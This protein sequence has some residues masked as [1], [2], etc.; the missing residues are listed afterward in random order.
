MLNSWSKRCACAIHRLVGV[1]N[2]GGV[3]RG[4]T[5]P[6]VSRL[7]CTC[8]L[9]MEEARERRFLLLYGSQT[10]QA[11]AIAEK[12]RDTARERGLDP[13]MHCISQS[14]KKV[15]RREKKMI[16]SDKRQCF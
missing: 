11:E 4:L 10:G 2:T 14:E 15:W 12:I 16:K 6:L 3:A 13:D 8:R 1:A 5:L 9:A 7:D